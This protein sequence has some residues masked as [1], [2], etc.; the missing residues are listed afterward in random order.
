MAT[1]LTITA[2]NT[3]TTITTTA[4]T[5]ITA[6][7]MDMGM[8]ML[9]PIAMVTVMITMATTI[10]ITTTM[11]LFTWMVIHAV[12]ATF[13]WLSGLSH[14]SLAIS[15]LGYMLM[16]DTFG[17]LNIFVSSVVHTD[18]RFTKST[19]RYPFGVQR[20]EVLAGLSNAIFLLFI[21]MNM[22]KESLE[23][24]MLE[25]DHHGS[26]DHHG[27]IVRVPLF[28]T[29]LGLGATLVGAIGHQNHKQFCLLLQA[30]NSG[31]NSWSSAAAYN[32]RT[33]SMM[34]NQFSLATLACIAGVVLVWLFPMVDSLDNLV[35]I[36]QSVVMFALGLPLT[37]VL[38]MILLQ[39]T[40]P[41]AL[42]SVE[43]AVRQLAATD[44]SILGLDRS[45]VWA[46]TYG[47]LVG[48][49]VVRIAKEAD[50][51]VALKTIQQRLF[52]VLDVDP[53]TPGTVLLKFKPSVSEEKAQEILQGLA[54][55]EKQLPHLVKNVHLGINFASRAKGF[56]HGFTMIFDSKEALDTYDK[57]PEHVKLVTE[58][59][60]PNI[61]DI[62]AFDYEILPISSACHL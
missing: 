58:D 4:T 61:D 11:T 39:T 10:I 15:G 28:W 53:H 31:S 34:H 6:M 9:T 59:I 41:M 27:A 51:A 42:E 40:P 54:N 25:G 62:L 32:Q 50:E 7:D 56:T 45:H 47:Q 36:G 46:N 17:I 57:S 55:L 33:L 1:M 13:T 5:M 3:T 35:A 44:G 21:G 12:V 18:G 16:F 22:L 2:M 52:S 14:G 43:D 23:H 19:V 38:G 48:T 20:I 30:G 29:I 49:L 60:R 26:G 37:K 24:L 8:I